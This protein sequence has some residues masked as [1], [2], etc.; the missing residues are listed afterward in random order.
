MRNKYPKSTKYAKDPDWFT[1]LTSIPTSP[2]GIAWA[3]GKDMYNTKELKDLMK[4]MED[5][6]LVGG[7]PGTNPEIYDEMWMH[8]EN[9]K[10]KKDKDEDT[11][12]DG[13]ETPV[14]PVME[15]LTEYEQMAWDPMNYLDQ[16]RSKQALRASLQAKG[17]I[18][19]NETMTLNSG[20]LA[21]LF[22][23]KNY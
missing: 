19:D 2:W 8:L 20:G 5:A 14:A 13:P 10:R 1:E 16:I 4:E 12:G 3:I 15:E 6:G 22:R 21:N 9:K 23:V 7:P 11:G 18:Q 17:I